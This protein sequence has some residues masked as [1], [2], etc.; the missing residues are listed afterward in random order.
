MIIEYNGNTYEGTEKEIMLTLRTQE[1]LSLQAIADLMG[2]GSRQRVSQILGPAGKLSYPELKDVA[3]FD[4][5]DEVVAL[6]LGLKVS[7][8]ANARR[9]L[10]IKAPAKVNIDKRRERLSCYLFGKDPGPNFVDF[11]QNE[12]KKLSDGRARVMDEFY[13]F[14]NVVSSADNVNNDSDRVYRSHVKRELKK[15]LAN[16]DIDRLVKEGVLSE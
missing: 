15:T 7:R 4:D 3:T 12:L 5:A 9:K 16:Y 14:G 1:K 8:I 10:G 11:M 6:R 2:V 13:L